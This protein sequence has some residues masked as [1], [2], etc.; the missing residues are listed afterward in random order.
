MKKLFKW[1]RDYLSDR[2]SKYGL[3]YYQITWIAFFKGLIVGFIIAY[4]I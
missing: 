4:N 3:D 1:H 2:I